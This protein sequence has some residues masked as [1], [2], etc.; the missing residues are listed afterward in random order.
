VTTAAAPAVVEAG[1]F[2]VGLLAG[3]QGLSFGPA[4]AEGEPPWSA[5]AIAELLALPGGFAL[6]GVLDGTPRGY[7][8]ARWLP[9]D[10][11]ILS[12]GV[13]PALRRRGLARALLADLAARAAA[14]GRDRLILEV[15]ADNAAA[16]ALY[17]TAGFALD[18]RRPAYY[19]RAGRPVDA[20]LLS[21]PL[22]PVPRPVGGR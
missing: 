4:V 8:M 21:R 6:L 13:V 22:R 14:A 3:L 2:D 17:R 15:A 16:Q 10:C 19:R 1:P 9:D 12:L 20:L 5:A 7:L 11:E 18:G